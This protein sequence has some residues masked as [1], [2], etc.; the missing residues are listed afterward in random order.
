MG[1]FFENWA[2]FENGAFF[3]KNGANF[4]NGAK[5]KNLKCASNAR[6]I[7]VKCAWIL[8]RNPRVIYKWRARVKCAWIRVI[9]LRPL[10]CELTSTFTFL[11]KLK[12]GVLRR[13]EVLLSPPSFILSTWAPLPQARTIS[14]ILVYPV[15]ILQNSKDGSKK[16]RCKF[17]AGRHDFG[18]NRNIFSKEGR[19]GGAQWANLGH[20]VIMWSN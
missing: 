2:N 10:N 4:E 8:C 16:F 12:I 5:I 11:Q 9:Y 7:R 17:S 18:K 3:Q 6:E 13:K 1:H 14:I 20:H 15:I 19:W